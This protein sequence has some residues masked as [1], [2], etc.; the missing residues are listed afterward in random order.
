MKTQPISQSFNALLNAAKPTA[1]KVLT[2]VKENQ[3]AYAVGAT[4]AYVTG[5]VLSDLREDTVEIGN[6]DSA[7]IIPDTAG[8]GIGRPLGYKIKPNVEGETNLFQRLQDRIHNAVT[9]NTDN[10]PAW[11]DNS[12][13]YMV[14]TSGKLVTD[15]YGVLINPWYKGTPEEIIQ[16]ASSTPGF[17][18]PSSMDEFLGKGIM[19]SISGGYTPDFQGG[20]VNISDLDIDEASEH[21]LEVVREAIDAIS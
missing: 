8:E 18:K 12:K 6:H 10:P 16:N 14:T 9:I 1:K 21:I 15:D 7:D 4:G 11:L 13:P 2:H 20:V 19:D 3:G 5:K 17:V